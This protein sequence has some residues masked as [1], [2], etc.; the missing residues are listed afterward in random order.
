MNQPLMMIHGTDDKLVPIGMARAIFGAARSEKKQ[1]IE[2]D[3][4][5]HHDL[6]S[7]ETQMQMFDF[8]R[9]FGS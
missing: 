5:G 6:W 8:I 4:G 2:V 1:F 7:A 9:R 3:A